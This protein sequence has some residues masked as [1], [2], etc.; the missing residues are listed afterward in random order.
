MT[1]AS[2]PVVSGLWVGET[3][4]PLAELSIRSYLDHGICF[5]LFSYTAY[6]NLPAGARRE[7][8]A[9]VIPEGDIFRNRFGSLAAFADWFRQTWITRH[10][11][12]WSDLDVVCLSDAI[13]ATLPW[14]AK[15]DEDFVNVSVIGFDAGDELMEWLRKLAADPSEPMPWDGEDILALKRELMQRRPDLPWRRNATP[16]G[17]AGPNGLTSA[18]KWAGRLDDAA[19]PE[20]LYPVHYMDWRDFLDGTLH[21]SDPVFA[22]AWAVHLWADMHRH[23]P[24]GMQE[25]SPDSMLCELFER[26]GMPRFPAA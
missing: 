17:N 6:P 1:S 16:W 20:T 22:D 9:Q 23:H 2:K 5:R 12:F 25:L 10:G 7:D 24:E 18:L 21:C 15:Q 19:P 4:P 14:F 13:P 3:L 8:A 11:G 26:H